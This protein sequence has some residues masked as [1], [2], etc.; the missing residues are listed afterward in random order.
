MAEVVGMGRSRNL[1]LMKEILDYMRQESDLKASGVE[2]HF[3]S[4]NSFLYDNHKQKS[5]LRLW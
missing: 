2:G 5:Q 4:S 1:R 3:N